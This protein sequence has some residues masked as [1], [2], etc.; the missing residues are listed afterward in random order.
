VDVPNTTLSAVLPLDILD[1]MQAVVQEALAAPDVKALW[2]QQGGKVELES[3]ADFAR[4]I[5]QEIVR[6]S[7]IA[8][9][10]NI[11]LE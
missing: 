9:A 6:W 10:A 8:K 2:A 1:R 4:F 11:Q 7:A 3:R 5:D